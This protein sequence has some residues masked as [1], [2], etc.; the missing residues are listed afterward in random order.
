M[1]PAFFPCSSFPCVAHPGPAQH[2]L[3]LFILG[4]HQHGKLQVLNGVLVSTEH[5]LRTNRAWFNLVS[6]H[7]NT[8]VGFEFL[9]HS[10]LCAIFC[11]VCT[12]RREQRASLHSVPSLY[13]C[14]LIT[15]TQSYTRS[16]LRSCQL[17]LTLWELRQMSLYSHSP[18]LEVGSPAPG[19]DC[20]TSVLPC[21]PETVRTHQWTT[22][23]LRNKIKDKWRRWSVFVIPHNKNNA[24]CAGQW[25]LISLVT[26]NDVIMY[27]NGATWRD[28]ECAAQVWAVWR[29]VL[30]NWFTSSSCLQTKTC[31]H[32]RGVSALI[33]P[34]KVA[35]VTRGMAGSEQAP[36][37]D[38][39]KLQNGENTPSRDGGKNSCTYHWHVVIL[40][41]S[42]HLEFLA[43]GDFIRQTSDAIVS[44]VHLQPGNLLQQGLVPPSVVPDQRGQVSSGV[45]ALE[46]WYYWF[47]SQ[48]PD[49][50]TSDGV[51]W[52]QPSETSP[53]SS[54]SLA[55]VKKNKVLSTADE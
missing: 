39:V 7:K 38:G 9:G 50:L 16:H 24:Q 32:S 36:H 8:A 47:E 30:Y 42:G 22:Y 53:L 11:D 28:S 3:N 35:H 55:A 20:G 10:G 19:W 54:L 52:G 33:L 49:S 2:L 40:T 43:V 26:Q 25:G 13:V 6:S 37:I 48:L 46:L 45:N 17:L 29:I 5:L 4:L 51:W 21:L 41:G 14:L 31:E 1:F 27:I 23:P 44:P 34:H 15:V 12:I 18:C